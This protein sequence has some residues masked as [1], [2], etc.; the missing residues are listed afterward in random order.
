[1]HSTKAASPLY[2]NLTNT[3]R[4]RKQQANINIDEKNPQ[5]NPSISLK[6]TCKNSQHNTR[7]MNTV[8]HKKVNHNQVDFIPE[9]KG[10]FNIGKSINAIHHTNRIK[11]QNHMIIS[12]AGEKNDRLF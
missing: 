11:N 7:K 9:T 5:H 6:H 4:K 2:P 10:W 12:T 3:T 1:M 8:V